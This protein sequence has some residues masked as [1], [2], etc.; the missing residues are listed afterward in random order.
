MANIPGGENVLPSVKVIVETRSRGASVPIG[1]RTAALMGE[2][3]RTE[4]IIVSANGRGLDG[5]NE[6]YSGTNGRDGR[7]FAVQHLPMIANRTTLYKNGIPLVG[8]EQEFDED[9]G[10]FSSVYDYRV[11]ITTGHIE[12]QTGSLVDQGGAFYTSNALNTG[13][14]TISG[15][16]LVDEDAPTETWTIRCATIRRDGYG[17]PIDGYAK[18]I[19]QGSVSGVLLDGYGNVVT[20]QSD[21]VSVSNGILQFAILEGST[22]FREGDRFTVKVKGGTLS[23]G[24]SLVANYI[25]ELDLNDPEFFTDPDQ[26]AAKHGPASTTNLLSLGAQ[27]AFANRPPGVWAV[28]CAPSIPRRVSYNVEVSASGGAAAD[29]LHFNL[30]L[31]VVPDTDNN[32]NFFVTDAATEIESQIIPNKVAFYNSTYT[33]SPNAF[34]FGTLQYSYTVVLEDAVVKEGDDATITSIGPTSATLESTTVVFDS[35]DVGRSLKILVPSTNAGT[36]VIASVLDGIAT[37]SGGGAFV[38]AEDLEFE[39]IDDTLQTAKILFT[40]DLALGAG[41]SLRVSVIDDRDAD[42]FDVAWEAGLES[43]EAIELDIVVP[44]PSQ[45]ISSIF[46]AARVHCETM[47]NVQNDKERILFIG[48]IAGLTPNMLLGNEDAAVEDLGVL[49]G[50]Q[51]DDV[52]EIL[53]GD[54]EDLADYDVATSWGNTFRVVYFSS[55]ATNEIVVQIGGS[56]V[57]VSAF[58]MAAAAAGY[59]S[60]VPNVAIPLTRKTLAGFT[61]LRSQNVRP[62]IAQNL[63][64]AGVCLVQPVTGGGRVAWGKTTTSSVAPEEIELSVIFIRDRVAK[65][66]RRAFDSFIG[67]PGDKGFDGSLMARANTTVEG[68]KPALITDSRG[69]RIMQDSVDPRQWDVNVEV[70]PV[71]GVNW[72]FCKVGIGL[73]N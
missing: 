60:G 65:I 15:L 34:Y 49:E 3:S 57:S 42:F 38:N 4:R 2:G 69:L 63:A 56:R 66:L 50:I 59:L 61:I 64:A 41:D 62:I 53:S 16:S 20:W 68:M 27:L 39:V 25:C 6:D 54:T 5:Y 21:G 55:G 29:D 32:I 23:R 31:N 30:P 37:I 18:F 14:G 19:A 48:A 73:L 52:S 8:L 44:L 35:N 71:Y 22:A 40:D 70:V 17:D 26:L 43:L 7:H 67:N 24:D 51:G 45:T 10:S 47:S 11:D 33:A 58:F 13:N 72:I 1:V 12:L 9:S 46:Q 36:Y 28:Q